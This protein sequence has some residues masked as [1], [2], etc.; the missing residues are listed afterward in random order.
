MDKLPRT[1]NT[2]AEDL[3]GFCMTSIFPEIIDAAPLK[4]CDLASSSHHANKAIVLVMSHRL[5]SFSEGSE[6]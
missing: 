6:N 5:G 3:V 1:N 4:Q 2:S